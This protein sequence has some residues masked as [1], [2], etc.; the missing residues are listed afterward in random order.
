VP[1]L[2]LN[3]TA[4]E[5]AI[6]TR[7]QNRFPDL[8][9][10]E[11]VKDRL[12]TALVSRLGVGFGQVVQFEQQ[13]IAAG[14]GTACGTQ[15]TVNTGTQPFTYTCV[16]L[17]EHRTAGIMGRSTHCA[18]GPDAQLTTWEEGQAGS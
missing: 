3:L 8:N 13:F 15:L 17:A 6:L 2:S 18:P 1:N 4:F 9:M 16:R 11:F 10:G 12:F 7:L 5:Q 14:N